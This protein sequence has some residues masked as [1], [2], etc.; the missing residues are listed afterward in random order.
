MAATRT[1]RDESLAHL[2]RR[3]GVSEVAYES[4]DRLRIIYRP[5][6]NHNVGHGSCLSDARIS[7]SP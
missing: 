5:G 3:G 4:G 2:T 6:V 7:S 1:A